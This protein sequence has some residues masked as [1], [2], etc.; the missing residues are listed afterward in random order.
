MTTVTDPK[1]KQ[2]ILD[3]FNEQNNITDVDI[4]GSKQNI[5]PTLRDELLQIQKDQED[6]SFLTGVGESIV[7]FFSGTKKTEFAELPEIGEYTGEGAAKVALGLSLT[8]NQ[9]SQLD[10]ILN[11]V[12]GSNPMED[13]FGN[14]IVVMPDGKS[15]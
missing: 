12:P 1:L 15:F 4:S 13:K 3:L 10:I 14:L 9:R 6:K 8:P 7:D 11:Q 5:D 2:E